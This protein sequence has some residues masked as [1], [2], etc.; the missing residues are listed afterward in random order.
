[1]WNSKEKNALYKSTLLYS[2]ATPRAIH[3]HAP[4]AHSPSGTR[5]PAR[6]IATLALCAL[7]LAPR[8]VD[9][10]TSTFE[11]CTGTLLRGSA[12]WRGVG[13]EIVLEDKLYRDRDTF[14]YWGWKWKLSFCA[15]ST[16]IL[17][18]ECTRYSV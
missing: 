15:E 16:G 14:T 1:M 2:I 7:L 5:A 11:Y 18:P 8:G 13:A 12:L 10:Q 6:R 3:Q 17:R 4:S 9:L